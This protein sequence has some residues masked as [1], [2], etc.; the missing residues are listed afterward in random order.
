MDFLLEVLT[1]NKSICIRNAWHDGSYGTGLSK[2]ATEFSHYPIASEKNWQ[3]HIPWWVILYDHTPIAVCNLETDQM[4]MEDGANF[5][6]VAESDSAFEAVRRA[7]L[8]RELADVIGEARG[9][10]TKN[11]EWQARY[12]EYVK[13]IQANEGYIE[14][15]RSRFREWAPL[16]LYLNV[17]NAKK[18]KQ[19]LIFELRYLGQT[20]AQLRYKTALLLDTTGYDTLNQRDF[21]CTLSVH[22]ELWDSPTAAAFRSFFKEREGKRKPGGKSN[23]EHRLESLLLS[24]F[25]KATDKPLPFIQPVRVAKLRFPMPT[26]ISASRHNELKYSGPRGG[27]ID[28]FARMGKGKGT[29]L[30]ILELKDKNTAKEP[31]RDAVKQAIA[32]AVF[33]RELLRSEAGPAWWRLFGFGGSIPNRLKLIAACVMPAGQYDDE[34]FGRME[35]AVEEDVLQL[36]YIYFTEDKDAITDIRTSLDLKRHFGEKAGQ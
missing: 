21:G 26:P 1:T 29:S 5:N 19:Q 4:I 27:G 31:P 35:L 30:A 15:V 18:A 17:S 13:A 10:L 33:I 36:H 11:P 34:S 24:E 8:K 25:S 23:E 28:L 22:G 6:L 3:E 14:D 9:L 16:M 32:Y 12:M 7:A 2:E 20:V